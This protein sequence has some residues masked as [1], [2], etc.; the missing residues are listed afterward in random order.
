[1]QTIPTVIIGGGLSGLYAAYLLEKKG[2][3]YLL[4]EARDSLGGRILSSKQMEDL[5]AHS[6][7]NLDANLKTH[8]DKLLL[9][10]FD[11]GPSWFWPEY[12]QQLG[13]LIEELQLQS[14]SQF[15]EGDMML[16]RAANE[17]AVRAQGYKSSP[18]SMRLKG[19]MSALIEAL[20]SRLDPSRIIMG[21]RVHRLTKIDQHIEIESTNNSGKQD[22]WRAQQVLLALPPRL[23]VESIEFEPEL[24]TDLNMQWHK[25]ATWMAP[26]AKYFAVYE[27]PFWRE[28]GLSGAAR[29]NQGPMVEIH[30]ASTLDGSG[31]LFGFIGVPVSVRN[32]VSIEVLKTHCRDQ[33]IRLF[34]AQAATPVA[35]YLKDWA[36]DTLTATAADANGD[37]QHPLTPPSKAN[38]GVWRDCL[39]GI[40]S[41]WS[42]QFSG[43]LAGAVE[44]ASLGVES[45]LE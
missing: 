44:A 12:Q 27:Q 35:E 22:N 3:D 37:G 25:T 26:H 14:F 4:L 29:S 36:Q 9:N 21:Q 17:P 40:G 6:D 38:S 31:A 41:E 33:L 10:S 39:T 20:Y 7:T 42:P 2:I 34:G 32:S 43:Y 19:G 24:P 1:M 5:T 8:N 11:L 18:S 30:D 45:L 28:Q 16:E 23:V 13:H 15:E